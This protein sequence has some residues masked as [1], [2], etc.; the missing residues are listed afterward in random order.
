[1]TIPGLFLDLD[2]P[3]D[4]ARRFRK[5]RRPNLIQQ[6]GIW[7]DYT[8]TCYAEIEGATVKSAVQDYLAGAFV[9]AM[10]R[11][12]KTVTPANVRD[13][14]PKP[15]P[16]APHDVRHV[17]ESL[18]A[19]P[20]VHR[21]A[22]TYKSPS[23]LDGRDGDPRSLLPCRNGLFDL[24]TRELRE[25]SPEFF[26]T[27]CLPL[28]YDP[29]VP[30]PQKWLDFLDQV[31]TGRQHLIDAMQEVFGYAISGDRS[32]E[33]IIYHRGVSGSGK[34]VIFRVAEQLV[35]EQNTEALSYGGSESTL[36]DKHG[37]AHVENALLLQIS[38]ISFGHHGP[39]NKAASTRLK[40]IGGGDKVPVRPLYGQ[41]VSMRLPGLLMLAS[42]DIPNFGT[43][44]DALARRLLFFPHD[45]SFKADGTRDDTLK[46]PRKSPLLTVEALTGILNWSIA[47]LDRLK[48][49]GRFEEWPESFEIKRR[50]LRESNHV[51]AFMINEC[52]TKPG[53]TVEKTTLHQ[54]Y[55]DWC[56]EN[57]RDWKT[58]EHFS[59]HL[60][61]AA[62]MLGL[63]LTDRRGA[64]AEDGSRPREWVGICLNAANRVKYYERDA[65]LYADLIGLGIE[66][67]KAG[68]DAIKTE[69]KSGRP[70]PRT[71][72]PNADE[73]NH[74]SDFEPGDGDEED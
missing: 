36:G 1:M 25:H 11:D 33:K 4:V 48:A 3:I 6:N 22:D 23:W 31:F 8:G 35:G 53:R 32:L 17:V 30:V 65:E 14:I 24:T 58:E 54:V 37:L 2:H 52:T 26:C 56:A 39:A 59:G 18:A 41:T 19:L 61:R 57:D 7:Y 47:G 40:E 64:R 49:R 71:W 16:V 74:A 12:G 10:Q 38:D 28:N 72:S 20:E 45:V 13:N 27:Y 69:P 62:D 70:I 21:P 44:A 46:D 34:G 63:T 66:P 68:L 51:V 29:S 60:Q 50:M 43:N 42:N 73:R 9:G 67:T 15:L 55:R 5:T